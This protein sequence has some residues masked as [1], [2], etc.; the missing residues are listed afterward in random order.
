MGR[1]SVSR[2]A[3]PGARN[4]KNNMKRVS[5]TAFGNGANR[6]R[7]NANVFAA[8]FFIFIGLCVL[9][10]PV[11]ATQ[12]NN[13]M[14]VKSAE[15]YAKL[16]VDVPQEVL[17]TEWE[18]A[19]AYNAQLGE[20]RADDAW[21]TADDETSP[22]YLRYLEY[23]AVLSGTDAM[24]RIIIPSINSDLPIFHGTSEA[25]L[26]KGVGHLYGTDLPVGGTG[27]GEGRH[28]VLS[29]HTGIQTA[30]LWDNLVK[31]QKGDAFYLQVSGEKMKYEVRD[32]EVVD[33]SDTSSIK[34][35]PG[36]D[37]VTLIT[38]TPYGINTHRLLVIGYRVEMDPSDADA[39]DPMA[40][41]TQW[42]MWAIIAAATVVVIL[43]V[44][45][46]RKRFK[47]DKSESASR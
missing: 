24:G 43:V 13:V 5:K 32:I 31:V 9:L 16:E 47:S 46:L 41:P 6:K 8:L 37:L 45:W 15:Q 20:I 2:P 28:A 4:D 26:S 18:N 10:Y 11:V 33:P 27:D 19:Q 1:H 29:A 12:W 40:P 36:E 23:L 38:C 17:R 25:A 30:T 39:F 35:V 7:L 22:E 42:W 3:S 34:R 14:Q 44:I 21:T